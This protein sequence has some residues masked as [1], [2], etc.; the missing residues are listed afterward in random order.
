MFNPFEDNSN[1]VKVNQTNSSSNPFD[2]IFGGG[3][4]TIT[5]TTS[6]STNVSN[7]N[8]FNGKVLN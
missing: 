4:T 7:N 2:D 3:S 1:T 6:T 5:N 8:P